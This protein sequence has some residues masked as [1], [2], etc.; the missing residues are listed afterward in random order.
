MDQRSARAPKFGLIEK[1]VYEGQESWPNRGMCSVTAI[2][3][4][5]IKG[6]VDTQDDFDLELYV[7]RALVERGVPAQL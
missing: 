7:Y 6:Y 2:T 1:S 4:D 5:Q 3:A